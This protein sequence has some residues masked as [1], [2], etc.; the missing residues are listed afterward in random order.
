MATVGIDHPV[1]LPAIVA[2]PSQLRLHFRSQILPKPLVIHW[3]G[4][5]IRIV[6]R[7]IVVG[8]TVIRV[9]VVAIPP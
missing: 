3:R 9:S 1:N 5:V 8:V 2:A 6:I 7:V 4:V